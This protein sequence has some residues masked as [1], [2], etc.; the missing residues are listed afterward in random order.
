MYHAGQNS[1]DDSCYK[2]EKRDH[3]KMRRKEQR[4]KKEN[5]KTRMFDCRQAVDYNAYNRPDI[6]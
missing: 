6:L 3:V 2:R 4:M 1:K 5:K